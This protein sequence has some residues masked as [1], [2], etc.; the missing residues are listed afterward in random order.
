MNIAFLAHDKRKELMGQ[1]CFAYR[2]ILSKH[3]LCATNKTG[4]VITEYARLPVT[5]YLSGIQGGAQQIGARIAYNEIDLVILFGDQKDELSMQEISA[6]AR[7]C[8][9]KQ[10]P[11]ATNIATAEM[12]V[13]GLANGD[14][15]WRNN[16][17]S[18]PT[19]IS[20]GKKNHKSA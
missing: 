13:L 8:D 17:R 1:F 15:D 16:V 18:E 7:L 14:L 4:R 20:S 6:I 3:N 10:I 12:L 11:Y 19:D 5:R 9:Q 2:G